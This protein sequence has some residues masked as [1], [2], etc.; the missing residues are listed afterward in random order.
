MPLQLPAET[1]EPLEVFRPI[2]ADVWRSSNAL[3]P[4][5]QS[6]PRMVRLGPELVETASV[7]VPEPAPTPAPQ[8][9]TNLLEFP[10]S[11]ESQAWDGVA[12][13]ITEQPRIL[14]APELVPAEPALG[15]ILLE[16]PQEANPQAVEEPLRPASIA[17]RLS[18][19]IVDAS[20]VGCGLALWGWLVTKITHE[21]P[22]RPQLL[23][24]T[25]ATAGVLWLSYQY[26]LTVYAGT[27]LG[28]RACRLELVA[29][30]GAIPGRKQRRW[31]LLA[32]LLSATSLMLGYA[33]VLLDEDRLCWH[34]R[35]THSYLRVREHRPQ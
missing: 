30:D 11:M 13:P 16:S 7:P 27:S 26:L 25:I 9:P 12:E 10:R 17:R 19:V 34:D 5:V 28:L 33:W 29:F 35:I 21:V 31:R 18:A 6:E 1:S 8:P 15:G 23:I 24:S 3:E 22:P 14:D 4:A 2:S 32:S 20:I